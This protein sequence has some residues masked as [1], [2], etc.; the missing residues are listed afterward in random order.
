MKCFNHRELDAIAVCKH[1]GRAICSGCVV[2][3]SGM[4][5]CKGRCEAA[6][7][8]GH[9][10][11]QSRR[12][13]LAAQAPMYRILA[14]FC[15]AVGFAGAGVGAYSLAFKFGGI[16]EPTLMAVVGIGFFA[17]GR[18]FQLLAREFKRRAEKLA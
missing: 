6:V 7:E 11:T 13:S 18:S 10:E 16:S 3:S 8:A 4:S 12:H 15:Y 14:Y 9:I 17:M 5:A 2:E 1:C